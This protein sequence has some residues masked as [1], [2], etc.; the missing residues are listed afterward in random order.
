MSKAPA[1]H[2][3]NADG[4]AEKAC[5][6]PHPA[7]GL[8]HWCCQRAAAIKRS[9]LTGPLPFCTPTAAATS[10]TCHMRF[11]MVMPADD[12]YQ[13]YFLTGPLPFCTPTAAAT[14]PACHRRFEMV[15]PADDGYQTYP[16]CWPSFQSALLLPLPPSRRRFEMVMPADDGYQEVASLLAWHEEEAASKWR[17]AAP[18]EFLEA[19]CKAHKASVLVVSAS[20]AVELA[21]VRVW[22]P[23]SS[24]KPTARRTRCG[25]SIHNQPIGAVDD[26]RRPQ[27]LAWLQAAGCLE[28]SSTSRCA[29]SPA[30]AAI[31]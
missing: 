4:D 20:A 19:H 11:E 22:C 28:E 25:P 13:T 30:A 26:W 29:S 9:S 24:W 17:G 3:G 27:G 5:C 6:F 23:G 18:R 8:R 16:P 1:A 31:L 12:G 2:T 15:M 10:P 14:S 21:R 7:G